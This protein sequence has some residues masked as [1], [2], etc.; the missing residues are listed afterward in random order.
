M[1]KSWF[2]NSYKYIFCCVIVFSKKA[3]AI[4]LKDHEQDTAAKAFSKIL[5]NMGIPKTI[6][7]DQGSEL[8][9]STFQKLLDKHNIQIIFTLGHAPFV[10]VFNRTLKT[11]MMKY[12]KLTNTDNWSKMIGPCLDSYNSTKHSATGV[13]PNDVNSSNQVAIQRRL[14]EKSKKGHYPPVQIGD[15]V[16]VPVTHKQH[17]GFLDHW[18]EEISQ[19]QSKSHGLYMVDNV[20]HPRKDVQ[21][22]KGVVIKPPT[23]TKA[24]QNK[25]DIQNQVGKAQD[26][27]DV[28]DLVGKRTKKATQQALNSG[29]TT[30]SSGYSLRSKK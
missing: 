21:I 28:K 7:S 23:K 18:T 12:M 14:Y 8:K 29:I 13:A 9:N 22:V 4:P 3:D 24:Q 6:Y 15:S 19:V 26:N 25:N 20:L 5:D 1:K 30:R 17:K 2:N 10:E 16:R 11:M 27:P